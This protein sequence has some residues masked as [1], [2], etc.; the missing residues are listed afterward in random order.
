MIEHLNRIMGLEKWHVGLVISIFFVLFFPS[1]IL[2]T[3]TT[4]LFIVY[5]L[6]YFFRS[7]SLHLNN[8]LAL[9]MIVLYAVTVLSGLWA[10]ERSLYTG[11]IR[12]KVILLGIPFCFMVLPR[13]SFVQF[14]WFSI[15]L[16]IAVG[17]S[18]LYVGIHYFQHQQEILT[19]ISLGQPIPVPYKDHIRYAILLNFCLILALFHL[20]FYRKE[21]QTLPF[22]CW[23]GVSAALFFYIQFL[24]V[25]TGMLLSILIFIIFISYKI[26]EKRLY[27]KGLLGLFSMLIV[28]YTAVHYLPTVKNKL[29]YFS[30]DIE[31]YK[32]RNFQN[33]SDGERIE[34]IHQGIEVIKKHYIIGVGEGQ[35]VSYLSNRDLIGA[36]L[37]HNQFI[38]VWA[39]NGILGL[40][41]ML[42]IFIVSFSSSYR[43]RNWLVAAYAM[44]MLTANMLE[45]MLETQLGLTLFIIPLLLLDSVDL[46]KKI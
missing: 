20:D 13:W 22:L 6:I 5:T 4:I 31:K 9:S 45:P 18:A 25:K 38:V 30:W 40:A 8:R 35:L 41:C 34:S 36:K 39:Q 2:W 10:E 17:L 3:V 32:E 7:R 33:Y 21:D 42:A 26:M 27:L 23:A 15:A 12:M 28:L 24:A 14:R 1:H 43:R 46:S 16:L 29:S 11:A 19:S 44:A 37:P